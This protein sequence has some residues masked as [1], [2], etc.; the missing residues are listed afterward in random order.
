MDM[1]IREQSHNGPAVLDLSGDPLGENDAVTLKEKVYSLIDA[2]TKFVI[3][4]LQDVRHI[5]SAGLGGM[6][7]AM[8]A[9][10]RVGG[11]IFLA[12]TQ[13]NVSKILS[14][15]QLNRIIEAYPTL[16]EAIARTKR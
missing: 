15:T 14:I 7:C 5:N 1:K 3:L 8:T 6:V 2:G 4:N 11:D 10:R 12:N 16:D 9:L 13:Q